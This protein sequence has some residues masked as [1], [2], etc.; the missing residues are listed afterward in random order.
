MCVTEETTLMTPKQHAPRPGDRLLT[1]ATRLFSR[2]GI[3]ATGIDKILAEAGVAKM[4]LYNQFGSKEGLVFA[5]LEREGEAWRQWFQTAVDGLPGS[6]RDKLVGIFGVLE[7]WFKRDG[8]Y[9]C[10]FINAVAEHNKEDPRIRS[11]AMAHK[12]KI[13]LVIRDLADQAGVIDPEAVTESIGMLLD[14]AIIA[15]VITGTSDH[16]RRGADAVRMLLASQTINGQTLT[17]QTGTSQAGTGQTV[18]S[19][20]VASHAHAA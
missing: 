16:A 14:G 19:Q 4:T 7:Q 9:G 18:A 5:V 15:A 12:K 13:L 8:F 6:P 1:T 20:P 2:H 3:N 10:A 17:S 11:L